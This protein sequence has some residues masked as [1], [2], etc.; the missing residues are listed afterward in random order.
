MNSIPCY[1]VSDYTQ[2][3]NKVKQVSAYELAKSTLTDLNSGRKNLRTE[4]INAEANSMSPVPCSREKSITKF[5][6]DY[7]KTIGHPPTPDQLDQA[8]EE[9]REEID[10]VMTTG[11]D[12]MAGS[13]KVFLA[14]RHGQKEDS[15]SFKISLRGFVEGYRTHLWDI[16][17]A[18]LHTANQHQRPTIFDLSIY[19]RNRRLCMILG[20]KNRKDERML[21]PLEFEPDDQT[22]PEQLFPYIAQATDP[23][24]PMVHVDA[25]D[26]R[27]SRKFRKISGAAGRVSQQE[28]EQASQ[29]RN[30]NP[31]GDEIFQKTK[32]SLEMTGFI[33]P[34][35]VHEARSQEESE[36]TDGY[37]K[38]PFTCESRSSCPICGE[39]HEHQNWQLSIKYD[40]GIGVSNMSSRCYFLPLTSHAFLHPM[41]DEI[42]TFS[43]SH[44][45]FAKWFIAGRQGSLKYYEGTNSL[46]EF[47]DYVWERLPDKIAH[48]YLRQ[49]MEDQLLGSQYKTIQEWRRM[50]KSLPMKSNTFQ[51][52]DRLE[53]E[54]RN[55]MSLMGNHTFTSMVL[56]RVEGMVYTGPLTFDRNHNLLHFTNGVLD[57][58]SK[59]FRETRPDDLNTQ[60]TG[61]EFNPQPSQEALDLHRQ[62]MEK[63]YPD[64]AIREVAQRV[65]GSTL[66]GYN[67]GKKL[68]IFTDKGGETG[69]NNGKTKVFEIHLKTMGDYG[70]VPKKEFL[71][72]GATNSEGANPFMARLRGKRVA[73]PEE[74]EPH[75][76][77]AE[78]LI[79]ELTNG[80]NQQINVRDLYK[81]T[82]IMEN[83]AKIVIGCNHGKF[84][85]FDPYD[86]ALTKRFL[87]VPHI[88]HFTADSNS[89]DPVRH[90]YPE[91]ATVIEK[92][93]NDD[94]RMAHMLW[95]LEGYD[96]F[97]TVSFSND[98]LPTVIKEFKNTVLF[99]NTPVYCYLGEV[100]EETGNLSSNVT[101]D[102]V[103]DIYKKDRRSNR[104]LTLEQ[105]TASFKVYVN[106]KVPNSFQTARTTRG[107]N[108]G[109]AF[110]RG[111]KIKPDA[112]SMD[113][114]SLGQFVGQQDLYM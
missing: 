23:E 75:K 73:M 87:P 77:L 98:S 33:N 83:C 3:L 49:F 71:Y 52:L 76:K 109:T 36:D 106:S 7:D 88:S 90:V 93:D 67:H 101:V 20:L 39:E 103:W 59:I 64:P 68:F 29:P 28:E 65:L 38:I 54:I 21:K 22:A 110:A 61:Y 107:S 50:M 10:R 41:V 30:S 26:S 18:I 89:W 55:C 91:D 113:S 86:E 53:R 60:T 43:P 74:L 84:P 32:T 104:Y 69:G 35:Q 16:K 25:T 79:K 96:R 46:H 80:T 24:W 57:L 15:S 102:A 105:F 6:F 66:T 81:S 108:Q 111:M 12:V 51:H 72:D 27:H 44:S 47:K 97:R 94:C 114:T 17:N 2:R 11:A 42:M 9:V 63:V 58:E 95:C 4:V 92:L 62:F 100:L 48:E 40:W 5:F 78:G 99:K 112:G 45:M 19:S 31:S 13:Y 14:Q 1:V 34:R 56:K 70:I 82:S 37:I 85:R 8:Q